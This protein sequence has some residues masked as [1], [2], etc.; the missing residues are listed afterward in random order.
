MHKARWPRQPP[1]ELILG[2]ANVSRISGS[3]QHE[4]Y[5]VFDGKRDVGRIILQQADGQCL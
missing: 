1:M 2:H 3:W 4:D 5:D